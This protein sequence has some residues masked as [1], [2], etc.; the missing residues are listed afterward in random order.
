MSQRGIV[1]NSKPRVIITTD[2]EV[3]DMNSI[4]HLC[5]HLDQLD[6]QGIIYTSSQFH[7]N[8]DGKHTLEEIQPH[9]LC[10]G[11]AAYKTH[12]GYPH[13]DPEA[14]KL[15]SYRPFPMGWLESLW[16][17]EYA[18]AYKH[19]SKNSA[20]FPTPEY[21][22]SITK[23]GNYEFEGDVRFDTDGSDLIKNAILDEDER[24]LYLLSWGGANTIVRALMSIAARYK[25]TTVWGEI[26]HKVISKVRIAG[27]IH[28]VGQDNTFQDYCLP[29]YPDIKVLW[30][31]HMYGSYF[32]ARMAPT[33]YRY[34]YQAEWLKKNITFGHGTLMGKYHLFGD[35]TYLEGEPDKF[36]YGIT[37]VLD[38]GYDRIP[39]ME[40][41]P[42]SFLGEGDSITYVFLLDVGLRGLENGQYGT[43]EGRVFAEGEARPEPGYDFVDE[44][45]NGPDRFLRAYQEEWAAR[46][47]WCV[48]DY[49]QCNHAPI[50]SAEQADI[51]GEPGEIVRLSASAEDPDGDCLNHYW[52]YY[53]QG[54]RYEGG[55]DDIRV[56][57]PLRLSTSFRIPSDARPGDE[58]NFILEVQDEA[59]KPITRYAQV[60]VKVK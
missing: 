19:L 34:T 10:Q 32:A 39:R 18:E 54:S 50:V 16:K 48:K 4:L 12:T 31:E 7:F 52:F 24:I 51:Y 35:G 47:D 17:N 37:P 8:G 2:M 6:V 56:W 15:K 60:I 21:L 49:A 9:Y 44:G 36:Q 53:P 27:I 45:N 28:G 57:E 22:L 20:D 30:P 33:S 46:A 13:P 26:Y 1:M 14:G 41:K 11:E 23:Y 5:L 3:D 55:A 59:E 42:Y 43:L 29:T 40:F 25:E 38:W 58:F